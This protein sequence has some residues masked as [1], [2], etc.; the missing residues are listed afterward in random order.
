MPKKNKRKLVAREEFPKLPPLGADRYLNRELSWL[1]FNRRVLGEALETRHPL[2]ERVKFMAIFSSNLDEFFMVRVAGIR[3]QIDA[4]VIEPS[5]DGLSPQEQMAQIKPVVEQ[6]T[7]L[8]RR[9]WETDLLPQLRANG[10]MVCNYDE[11]D[12]THREAGRKLFYQEIFPVLTPLAFDPGHPFPHISNLSLSLAVVIADRHQGERFARV[13]VPEVL[14]RLMQL[15]ANDGT[16]VFVWLE[17][18]IAAH[19]GALFPGMPVAETY[20]FRVT[21]NGDVD[22]QEEEAADLLRTI[23]HGIRQR[24]FGRVVRLTVD[25][26]MPQHVL[27]IL[28]ENMEVA[29]DDLYRVTGPLG[30]S[31]LMQLYNIDRPDLKDAPFVPHV[32]EVLEDA[33]DPFAAIH[34]G[35]ILLHHP[36]DSFMPVVD[37]IQAAAEDPQVLAIKQTL[38]R[39]G[40]NTPLVEAL[41]R[42]RENG[43]QVTVLMELK[44]RF[45]EENNIEWAKQ[46][47]SVGVHVVYGLVGLKTH[48]K[49]ALI[50]RKERDGIRRYVH[51]STGNYNVATAHLYTDLGLLTVNPDFGADASDVFNYLT[52][53]SA[54]RSYR[55]FLVAP[56]NA[57]QALQGLIER[58]IQRH[59]EQGNGQLILK[60]NTLTDPQM[61]EALYTASKAGVQTDLIIRGVC[62]LRPGVPGI[63]ERIR[64][65]SIIGRFLEHSRI[66][67]FHNG[68]KR[69]VYLGSAD[70]MSRNLNRR[71]EVLFPVHQADLVQ[72]LRDEILE[73]YLHDTVNA[74]ELRADGTYVRPS[75]DMPMCDTQV[76][77]LKGAGKKSVRVG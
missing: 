5:P 50:V 24:Q 45:D 35:D 69:E 36:F 64:V 67:Y 10:I 7:E 28:M 22:L 65:R 34:S 4:G 18:L 33:V 29:P 25:Q 74:H 40:R 72:R 23:E 46:L 54:Q 27:D 20:P 13:K 12:P 57:R 8:Q 49:I 26:S 9:C 47:E 31:Q 15:P 14:P 63:S 42:A 1:Q 21:R 75:G 76:M 3:E 56:V 37:L 68:G 32:P 11:L 61:I 66:Y 2:L 62:C 6:L 77:L 52:G 17:Q 41:I 39:V 60:M 30:L 51:L 53:Y 59:K 70:L 19:V 58:E 71:V 48:C 43:K 16:Q 55:Q 44:A 38:Y 73:S